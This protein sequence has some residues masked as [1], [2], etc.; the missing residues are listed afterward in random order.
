VARTPTGI[1][2]TVPKTPQDDFEYFQ[3]EQAEEIKRYYAEQG[4]VVIRNLI[5]KAVCRE[6]RLAFER[7]VK[8]FPGFIYRQTTA[9]PERHAFSEQGFM[10]NP[11]LNVQSMDPRQF[12]QFRNAGLSVITHAALQKAVYAL[13]GE[14]GKLVQSMYFEGNPA[15]W[16]HQDTYYLDAEEIGRMT[17]AWISVEEIAPG[18]GRFFIYPKSHLMD[19]VKNGGDHDIAFHH[20]RYKEHVLEIINRTGMECRA[21]AL[22]EGDVL[23]WASKTIHGS[24]E[25]TQPEASRSSFTA[26]FIPQSSRFLQW[27]SRIK[28]LNLETINGI[29]VHK[30]K[31]LAAVGSRSVFW[32]ETNFPR[33]F[34]TAKKVGV[35]LLT[36]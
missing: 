25:T 29:Q 32:V 2:I 17:A 26:H 8:P 23:L 3:P 27:Q 7:E 19:L 10:L 22:G 1:S 36:R 30:P 6:A 15:T 11:I 33:A 4:Y 18:A 31:D 35:K 34:Q 28:G 21:P 20:T 12:P 5:P 14:T 24:L 13:F 16:P 9:N